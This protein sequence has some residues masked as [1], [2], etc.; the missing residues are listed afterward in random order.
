MEKDISERTK[1]QN[2]IYEGRIIRVY[3]DDVVLPNGKEGRREYVSHRGGAAILPVDEEG[4]VYLVR[5]YRYPYHEV[6]YEIP[7]GKLEA[8]EDPL[9]TAIRELEEETGMRSTDLKLYGVLYPTPGYTNEHLYV[10]LAEHLQKGHVHL[11]PDEFV[12]V[13]R[14]PFG[15]VY[16]MV[17]DNTIT[18]A[19]TCYAV[20]RYALERKE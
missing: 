13:A 17:L 14:L 1:Q 20:M 3:N 19:K 11:D 16:Q 2:L 12:R 18:D 8:G 4:N 15:Q 7:A 5:Q 10:Y 9:D 6:I